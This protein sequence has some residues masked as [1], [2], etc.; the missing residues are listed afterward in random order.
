MEIVLAAVILATTV[1]AVVLSLRSL[2]VAFYEKDISIGVLGTSLLLSAIVLGI[3][4][5]I[6]LLRAL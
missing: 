6:H 2:N 4:S 3:A 1:Y 5:L